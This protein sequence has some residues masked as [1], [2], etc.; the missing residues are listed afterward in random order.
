[1]RPHNPPLAHLWGRTFRPVTF[2]R[3]ADLEV[4]HTQTE[5][6]AL[7]TLSASR[8][9]LATLQSLAQWQEAQLV[10]QHLHTEDPN[11]HHRFD[12]TPYG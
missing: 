5:A 4:R 7:G 10:V 8:A 12:S 6:D 1:M 2:F 11:P 9:Q 3:T